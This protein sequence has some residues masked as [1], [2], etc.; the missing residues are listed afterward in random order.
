MFEFGLTILKL[1]NS[2]GLKGSLAPHA[3]YSTSVEL[4]DAIAKYDKENNFPFSIHNQETE[5][6]TKFFFGQENDFKKLYDFLKLDISWFKAPGCSSLMSYIETIKDQKAILVHNTFS[7]KQDLELAAKKNCFFCF[8][9]NANLYIENKLPD[10][11]LFKNYTNTI[12]FGTDSLASNGQL[13]L[14]SEA[15]IILQNS[16]FSLEAVLQMLTFNGADALAIADDFGQLHV[17]KNAGLNLLDHTN[18]QLIFNKK[19]T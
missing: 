18:N 14:L 1:L 6:E 10:Y 16:N 11:N 8:C 13:D 15:N 4:I 9:P 19:L 12:C 17:G 7:D 2:F 5:H 3:P